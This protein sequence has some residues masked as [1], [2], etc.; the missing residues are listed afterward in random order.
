MPSGKCNLQ[1]ESVEANAGSRCITGG[2]GAT[3]E[4]LRQ[5]EAAAGILTWDI[6]AGSGINKGQTHKPHI[7]SS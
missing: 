6:L 1:K 4:G 3:A 2:M 5:G 7:Q